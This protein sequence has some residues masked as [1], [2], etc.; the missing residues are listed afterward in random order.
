MD[1]FDR[2]RSRRVSIRLRRK[3]LHVFNME[4]AGEYVDDIVETGPHGLLVI[5]GALR[6]PFKKV[7]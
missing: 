4:T 2:H 3:H 7:L 1:V 6:S 5:L